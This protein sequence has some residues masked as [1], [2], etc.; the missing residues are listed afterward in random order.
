MVLTKWNDPPSTILPQNE[1]GQGTCWHEWRC[2]SLARN[3]PLRAGNHKGVNVR[4]LFH[5]K[6]IGSMYLPGGPFSTKNQ[7]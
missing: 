4:W 7:L 2:I 1:E 5:G 6:P 3:R